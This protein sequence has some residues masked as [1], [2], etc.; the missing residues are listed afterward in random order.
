V[1]T[2][3]FTQ[4][5]AV[6]FQSAPAA[7]EIE[8]TLE[9]WPFAG[10]AREEQGEDGWALSAGGWVYDVPGGVYAAV[11]I[12][13]RRWPDD[14]AAATASPTLG[15]AWSRGAF[16]PAATPGALARAID[17]PWMWP[18]GEEA[19]KRH[20][21]FV[22]LRTG[23]TAPD[24]GDEE[25]ARKPARDPVFE[26]ALLTE[27]AQPILQRKDALAF[28]VPAGEALRSREQIDAAL[29]RKVGSGPPPFELW[30]NV[31]SV[32]LSR[33]NDKTWLCLDVVGMGQLGLPDLEAIFAEGREEPAAVEQLLRNSCLHL[34]SGRPV[35][36][37]ST[38]DDGK[39]R[40]WEASNAFA[41]VGPRRPVVRWVPQGGPKPPQAM[42]AKVGT[43]PSPPP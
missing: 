1:A 9:R 10:H 35:A 28:F 40:R 31:R 19:A 24:P 34:I 33:E 27:L 18:E 42:L 14:G 5:V 23:F 4:C 16:G 21:A 30:T 7:E 15:A 25:A 11:D 22:R 8:K 20:E 12:V 26:L 17:Q 38:S 6:L 43:K 29:G 13:P 36:P 3:S 39:G 2:F 41:A 32:T 37:G